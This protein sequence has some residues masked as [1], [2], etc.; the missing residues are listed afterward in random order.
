MKRTICVSDIESNYKNPVAELVEKACRYTSNI[1][2]ES[3]GKNINAKSLM[4]VMAFGLKKG[5]EVHIFTE[6][7]DSESAMEGIANF[8]SYSA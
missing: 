3:G 2:L 5:M 8:L 7:D 6:G 4:G 1:G